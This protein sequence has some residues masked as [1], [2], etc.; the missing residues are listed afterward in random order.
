[1]IVNDEVK[2]RKVIKNQPLRW[3]G[4]C[5][6][7]SRFP[8]QECRYRSVAMPTQLTPRPSLRQLHFFH[9]FSPT[10]ARGNDKRRK[11]G[12]ALERLSQ[13]TIYL[14]EPDPPG[15]FLLRVP[16]MPSTVRPLRSFLC[17]RRTFRFWQSK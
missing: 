16:P 17:L 8:S 15:W 10:H 2:K 4:H 13:F 9:P 7:F 1:M 14:S 12:E 11:M 6:A 3:H 5:C